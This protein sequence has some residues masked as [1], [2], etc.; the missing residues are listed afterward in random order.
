[1][2]LFD[3]VRSSTPCNLCQSHTT[4]LIGTKGRHG[5]KL[6]TLL[7]QH[8]GLAWTDPT[9][10]SEELEKFYIDDYRE[11]YKGTFEPK[12]KHTYRAGRVALKR[13]KRL[14]PHLPTGGALL[15]VGSGGG[16]FLFLMRQNGYD[17]SGIEPNRG[18]GEYAKR[19]LNLPITL[20][21]IGEELPIK[22]EFQVITMFHVLEHLRDPL[23][24]IQTLARRLMPGGVLVIEVPNLM[25]T[26]HAPNNPYHYAHLFH[27]SPKTLVLL[28]ALCGLRPVWTG[29]TEDGDNVTIVLTPD[30]GITAVVPADNGPAIRHLLSQHT[31]VTHYGRISTH[32]RFLKKQIGQL[33]EMARVAKAKDQREALL[34]ALL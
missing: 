17:V 19:E 1:M 27:F 13:W 29:V 22:G 8:C 34:Q 15:D 2:K 10:T 26:L 33:I 28:G 7:C 5:Q 6:R 11:A 14:A 25:S 9:P 18:Y 12:R 3:P 20:S 24:M 4:W 31:W 16:E 30:S 21:F 23:S 32:G